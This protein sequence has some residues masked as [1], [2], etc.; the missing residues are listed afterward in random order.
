[1]SPSLLTTEALKMEIDHMV[2]CLETGK[3]PRTGG[4]QA[5]RV[6]R[7]LEHADKL[8]RSNKCWMALPFEPLP[9]ESE[10]VLMDLPQPVAN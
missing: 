3:T 7:L 8:A 9:A 6:V 2:E 10:E 1:Y 4:L 5:L